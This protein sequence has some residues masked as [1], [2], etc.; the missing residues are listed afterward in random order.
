MTPT[1]PRR[2]GSAPEGRPAPPRSAVRRDEHL[3]VLAR[4]A[5]EFLEQGRQDVEADGARDERAGNFLGTHRSGQWTNE[6]KSAQPVF[7]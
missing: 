1:R 5:V 3:R 4:A 2:R 6:S 7:G